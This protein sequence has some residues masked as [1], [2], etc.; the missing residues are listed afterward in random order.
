MSGSRLAPIW[1]DPPDDAS[2]EDLTS[3]LEQ[4]V[5]VLERGDLSL[6]DS[7]AAYERGVMIVRRCNDLLD[8]A[9]LRVTELASG[10]GRADGYNYPSELDPDDELDD[11]SF[12][13]RS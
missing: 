4:I 7:L 10:A 12:D 2:F 6:D 1:S 9:E 8:R 13:D 3:S 11:D 5:A